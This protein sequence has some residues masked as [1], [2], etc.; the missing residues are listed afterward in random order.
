[1]NSLSFPF[2]KLYF[3]FSPPFIRLLPD[4]L[5]VLRLQA[6]AQFAGAP[7]K[8]RKICNPWRSPSGEEARPSLCTPLCAPPLIPLSLCLEGSLPAFRTSQK[9]TLSRTSDIIIHLRKQVSPASSPIA[10]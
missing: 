3:C 1:P 2:I 9:E 5:F 6:Y 4:P 8:V 10:F 7:L